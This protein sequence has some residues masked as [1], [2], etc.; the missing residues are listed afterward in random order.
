MA[1]SPRYNL[2]ERILVMGGPG[3]GKSYAWL[4][5]AAM[6]AKTKSDA[7]F[8]CI[9]TDESIQRMMMEEFS[10][11][12][13]VIVE[14]AQGWGELC[15]ALERCRSVIRPQDWLIAD[16]IYP[17]WEEAQSYFIQEV[18]GKS[19]GEYF[20]NIR[21]EME[22]AKKKASSL[23]QE[24]FDGWK[25]WSVI[26]MLYNDWIQNFAF[27][28]RANIFATTAVDKVGDREDK[29][30][31]MLFGEFGVKPRGQKRLGHQFHTV[32]W[33][34]NPKMGEWGLTTIKDRG[35]NRLLGNPLKNFSIDYMVKVAKWKL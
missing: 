17:V 10:E 14:P 19:A 30:N 20:L 8:Y 4:T 35:R 5:I 18:M 15:V 27:N 31:R 24:G 33:L 25:D 3:T 16:M 23:Y 1:F 11:L 9:D 6:S 12:S 21:R 32:L 26:N 29:A 13:N 28:T 2:R 34:Q 22:A 7:K